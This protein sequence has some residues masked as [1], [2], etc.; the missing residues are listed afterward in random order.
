M[1]KFEAYLHHSSIPHLEP[2]QCLDLLQLEVLRFKYF[3]TACKDSDVNGIRDS[4]P[5]I[6]AYQSLNRIYTVSHKFFYVSPKSINVGR[7][8][9]NI[10]RNRMDILRKP[11]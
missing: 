4:Q 6:Q 1:C 9:Q 5:V 2:E 3:V 11:F 10:I 7:A 8:R